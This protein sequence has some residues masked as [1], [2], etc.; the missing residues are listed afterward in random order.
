M[1]VGTLI[2]PSKPPLLLPLPLPEPLPELELL[3]P[4]PHA[5]AH[6]VFQQLAM[7]SISV[8]AVAGALVT[9]LF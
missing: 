3:L 5:V 6:D 8:C 9:Q 1:L 7:F 4:P 2:P